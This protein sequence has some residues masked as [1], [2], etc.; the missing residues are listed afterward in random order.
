MTMPTTVVIP[1]VAGIGNALMAVPMVRQINRGLPQSRI[2]ILARIDAMAEVFRRLAEVDAVHVTGK[3]ARGALRNVLWARRERADYYVVPFPSNRWQYSMLALTSGA[4]RRVLHSYPVGYWRAMHF[5]GER[6]PAKRGIH[7][8]VQNLNLLPALGVEP[9][10]TDAPTFEPSEDDRGR[11][12]QLLGGAESFIAVHAGSARTVLAQAKRWPTEKYARLIESLTKETKSPIVLL[13]GPDEAGVAD[14]ILTTSP[15]A[16]ASVMKLTGP[17]GEAAAV[18]ERAALYVG[19]DSGL[20][21]LAAAVGTKAVT[22]F[23]PAD[24]DR[25]SPFGHRD[26]V[27]QALKSCGPCFLYPWDTPYP[28]I[29][30]K[31]PYCVESVTVE[32]VME[33]VKTALGMQNKLAEQSS[34]SSSNTAPVILSAAKDLATNEKAANSRLDPSLR[35]G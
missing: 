26:L 34:A 12:R 6:L 1:I 19:S 8:V 35:S 32:A 15:G 7:D 16:H 30:C 22:I 21:H 28:K 5:V 3:G 20:A 9:D 25:V 13:E 4:K 24:P 10:F 23:G 29:R 14:E 17:L 2:V 11:A 31:P 27:V 33:K 18:L